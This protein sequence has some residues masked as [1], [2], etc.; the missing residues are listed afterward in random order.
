MAGDHVLGD[1]SDGIML[2]AFPHDLRE[3]VE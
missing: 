1:S 2:P 3:Q